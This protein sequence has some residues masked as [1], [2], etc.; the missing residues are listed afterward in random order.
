M[1]YNDRSVCCVST[2]LHNHCTFTVR[3][4][5]VTLPGVSHQFLSLFCLLEQAIGTGRSHS[6][7]RNLDTVRYSSVFADSVGVV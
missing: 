2:I 5:T 6:D 3:E 1:A 7:I 4:I